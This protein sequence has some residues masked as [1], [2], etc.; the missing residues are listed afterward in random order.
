MI[1]LN[2]SYFANVIH[3]IGVTILLLF[4]TKM[5]E[6]GCTISFLYMIGLEYIQ[7]ELIIS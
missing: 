1:K 5:E 7:I 4:A 6:K 2:Y 3:S